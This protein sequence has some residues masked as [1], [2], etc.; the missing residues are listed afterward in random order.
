MINLIIAAIGLLSL[1]FGG[2]NPLISTMCFLIIGFGYIGI[3]II[4]PVLMGDVI[5]HDELITGKRREA[6]YGG[7]NAVVTK[8]AISIASSLFLGIITYF[9]F[10]EHQPQTDNGVLGILIA[11]CLLP[12]ILLIGCAIA[13]RWFPLDG[14][15]WLKKK[16]Y[17]LHL[18]QK[19]EEEY[20]QSLSERKENE[21]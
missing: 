3:L 5:D 18:H 2:R 16:E 20:L 17:I 7:V 15:E 13:L 14:P 9:G 21:K 4:I 10:I 8:P 19:K 6:I 1:F 11:F 12:A